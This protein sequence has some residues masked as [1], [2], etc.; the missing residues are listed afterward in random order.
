MILIAVLV[1]GSM[2]ACSFTR[3]DLFAR[4]P[5]VPPR[6]PTQAPAP[7]RPPL[8][9]QAAPRPT[10]TTAPAAPAPTVPVSAAMN[11]LEAQLTASDLVS[12]EMVE[13][14]RELH[15]LMREAMSRDLQQALEE[16]QRA[17]EQAGQFGVRVELGGV[18]REERRL[19]AA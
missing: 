15:E 19:R 17:L 1:V 6:A 10:A 5:T 7:T 14:V 18:A 16:M 9:T 12:P 4:D 11:Q 8:A 3:R 2:A 13:K